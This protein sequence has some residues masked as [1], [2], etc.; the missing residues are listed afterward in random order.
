MET[1]KNTAHKGRKN[2]M[3][4]GNVYKDK[5]NGLNYVVVYSTAKE[6]LYTLISEED[7]N[8]KHRR[9]TRTKEGI[10]KTMYFVRGGCKCGMFDCPYWIKEGYCSIDNPTEECD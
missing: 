3:K 5:L 9:R 6:E 7:E 1:A 2:K 4:K 8:G 10:E